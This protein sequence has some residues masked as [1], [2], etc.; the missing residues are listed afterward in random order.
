MYKKD[1]GKKEE[2]KDNRG[3]RGRGSL[4]SGIRGVREKS[5]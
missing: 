2:Q 5:S 3:E 1:E 4:N